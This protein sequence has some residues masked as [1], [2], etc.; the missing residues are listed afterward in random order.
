MQERRGDGKTQNRH[1]EKREKFIRDWTAV[2][3]LGIGIATEHMVVTSVRRKE[4]VIVEP[5]IQTENSNTSDESFSQEDDDLAEACDQ[6]KL[7]EVRQQQFESMAAAVA[8]RVALHRDHDVGVRGNVLHRL[9]EA[10]QSAMDHFPHRSITL[11][12]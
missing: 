2:Y 9:L 10:Q 4:R 8:E 5:K 12:L 1:H 7:G 6:R 11:I 3:P